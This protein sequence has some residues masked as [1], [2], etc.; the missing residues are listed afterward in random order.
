[1]KNTNFHLNNNFVMYYKF[2]FQYQFNTKIQPVNYYNKIQSQN[3]KKE[4][5][6]QK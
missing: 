2:F 3:H 6:K 5:I 1:M 4:K